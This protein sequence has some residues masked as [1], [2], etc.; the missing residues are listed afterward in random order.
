M[1]W[2]IRDMAIVDLRFGTLKI[3]DFEELS[4]ALDESKTSH[5]MATLLVGNESHAIPFGG[6]HQWPRREERFLA[7]LY[8]AVVL[9]QVEHRITTNQPPS[10]TLESFSKKRRNLSTLPAFVRPVCL[11]Y[12]Q[13]CAMIRL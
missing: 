12:E 4:S 1:R 6:A 3:P 11:R 7:A 10:A 5:G 9:Q 8:R 13:I 2:R